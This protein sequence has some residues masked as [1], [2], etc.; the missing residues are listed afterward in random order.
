MRRLSPII[1]E[2]L[3]VVGLNLGHGS[4]VVDVG[5]VV[6]MLVPD[7]SGRWPA[8][9][10]AVNLN[11]GVARFIIVVDSQHNLHMPV[12]IDVNDNRLFTTRG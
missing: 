1:V 7:A 8:L 6:G 10:I 11:T 9:I 5:D 2:D 4:I 3:P 12:I